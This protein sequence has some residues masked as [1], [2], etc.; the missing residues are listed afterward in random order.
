[1]KN[2]T[3]GLTQQKR[4]EYLAFAKQ[5]AL[6]AGEVMRTYFSHPD[7][8]FKADKTI[9]TNADEEINQLVTEKIKASYPDHDING[10]EADDLAGS[11]YIWVC[12]PIDGTALYA[13]GIPM[14]VF[15]LSLVVDGRPQVG[16]VYDPFQDRLYSGAIGCGA[17]INGKSIT[18]HD[19]DR[20]N[21]MINFEW[22]PGA[23]YNVL[24]AVQKMTDDGIAYCIS[25]GSATHS[26]VLVA[27]GK[28]T[29]SIFPGTKG[30]NVDI[31]AVKVIVE[32]AG[33]KVTD[34]YGNDQRYDQ[35]INGAVV[36]NGD[37]TTR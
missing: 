32:E 14:S 17:Q 5:L 23:E 2:I 36:S 6:Q 25:I 13:R 37:I 33:G 7:H 22:W 30:K 1:M 16:V 28:L 18:V 34:F 26:S 24:P 20:L 31:A 27:P 10:E 11:D 4:L 19:N 35:D 29:A 12:D 8:H 15:S 9:V 3:D 21:P